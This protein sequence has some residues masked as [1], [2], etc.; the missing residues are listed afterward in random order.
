MDPLSAILPANRT[1]LT[2]KWRW[3]F[4]G[5]TNNQGGYEVLILRRLS[6]VLVNIAHTP[7]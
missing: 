1:T 5:D 2:L 4:D 7:E 6:R 3:H